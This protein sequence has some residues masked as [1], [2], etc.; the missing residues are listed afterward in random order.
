M[1]ASAQRRY[2][3]AGVADNV[4]ADG[5]GRLDYRYVEVYTSV[6]PQCNDK[7]INRPPCCCC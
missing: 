2:I 4:R 6:L 7:T 3:S 1:L 5:R